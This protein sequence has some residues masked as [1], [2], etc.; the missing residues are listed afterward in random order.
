MQSSS[1]LTMTASPAKAY[2]IGHATVGCPLVTEMQHRWEAARI[3][4]ANGLWVQLI[5]WSEKNLF[6]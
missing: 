4:P 1:M 2:L 3:F 6:F 5:S